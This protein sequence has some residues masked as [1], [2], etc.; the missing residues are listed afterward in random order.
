MK[1]LRIMMDEKHLDLGV[2][3]SEENLAMLDN[4][5]IIPLYRIGEYATL[6]Q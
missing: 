2:R 4:I 1:S 6:L 5:R 3:T